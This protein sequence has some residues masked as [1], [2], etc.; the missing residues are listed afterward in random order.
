MPLPGVGTVA[1]E[2]GV[3]NE[4]EVSVLLVVVGM[5]VVG[6]E[7]ISEGC[8]ESTFMKGD[9]GLVRSGLPSLM[10]NGAIVRERVRNTHI[11]SP[12]PTPPLWLLVLLPL[13]VF[14]LTNSNKYFKFGNVCRIS[15]THSPC[16]LI[17]CSRSLF[18]KNMAYSKRK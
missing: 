6:E 8:R 13:L 18:S 3:I 7:S 17:N 11:I 5:V 12:R 14:E 9:E 15:M 10:S 2:A 4:E 1:A 16:E